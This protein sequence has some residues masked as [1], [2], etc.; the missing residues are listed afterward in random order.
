MVVLKVILIIIGVLVAIVAFIG[1]AVVLKVRS[2]ANKAKRALLVHE[3]LASGLSHEAA[4]TKLGLSVNKVREIEQYLK[5]NPKALAAVETMLALKQEAERQKAAEAGNG[6]V[7]DVTPTDVTPGDGDK[8]LLLEDR[9]GAGNGTTSD[10]TPAVDN[11]A[12]GAADDK[13][14][15]N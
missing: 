14:G 4:A 2:F 11:P 8:P 13:K 1:I 10:T 5:D 9:T 12:T 15:T 6:T 3:A 7:I